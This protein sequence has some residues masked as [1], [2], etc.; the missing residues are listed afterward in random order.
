MRDDLDADVVGVHRGEPVRTDFA[1]DGNEGA[2]AEESIQRIVREVI[3][4]R[5]GEPVLFERVVWDVVVVTSI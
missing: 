1:E 2:D 4:Q 5:G 3:G